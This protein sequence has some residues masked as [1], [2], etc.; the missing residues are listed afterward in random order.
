MDPFEQIV[1]NIIKAQENI[2]GPLAIEQAQKVPG[3]IIGS[4]NK[5]IKFNGNQT[6]IVEGL[7]EKYRDLFGTTSV[8]VCKDAARTVIPKLPKEKVPPILAS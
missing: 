1:S 7:V 3:L 4:D 6:N 8:E 2:I 5:D